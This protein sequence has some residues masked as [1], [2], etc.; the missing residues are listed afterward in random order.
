MIDYFDNWNGIDIIVSE[1]IESVPHT[2]SYKIKLSEEKWSKKPHNKPLS[3]HVLFGDL[4]II[5]TD[6]MWN[7]GMLEMNWGIEKILYTCVEKNKAL[8]CL[9]VSRRTFR[10]D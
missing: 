3:H 5:V 9:S 4:L 6:E 1:R 2:K 10:Y 8:E 7:E